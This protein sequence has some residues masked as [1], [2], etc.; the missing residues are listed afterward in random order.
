MTSST[1]S[2]GSAT[3]IA[4]GP[5]IDTRP[6]QLRRAQPLADTIRPGRSTDTFY[7]SDDVVLR[8]HTSPVQIRT[9]EAEPPPVYMATAGRCYRR[10][11]P[12]ATHTADVHPDRGA[13]G[14]PRDHARPSQGHAAGVRAGDLRRRPRGAPAAALLPVH[15]AV[16]RGRREL[17][18]LRPRRV[19]VPRLQGR[20]LGRDPR[21]GH[22]RPEPVRL[23]GGYDPERCRGSRSDWVSSAWPACATTS[24][25]S[26][27]SGRTTCASWS[28]SDEGARLVAARLRL[29]RDARCGS[30]ASCMSMT[31]T[32]LEALHRPR[33]PRA[34]SSS[35]GWAAC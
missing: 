31:G 32:K 25:T 11:T 5:E 3:S 24:P 34:A 23:R 21:R 33:R 4:D 12:D 17:L 20:G 28:S 27:S 6:L 16:G 9:M 22:G 1:C 10:D 7:V 8:T 29:V 15:R 19:A 26:G 18:Q 13:R 35:T 30:W 2:S 14:R